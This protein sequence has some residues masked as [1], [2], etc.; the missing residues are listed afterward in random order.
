MAAP[1][2][3]SDDY[4]RALQA[5]MPRGPAWPRDPGAL[6]TKILTALAKVYEAQTQRSNNLLI[7]AF[8]GS[9]VELLPEWEASLG[10]PSTA[11]GP[12]P[13]VLARQTLVIAR[14]IGA[15]G[16]SVSDL[17]LYATL[18]G[19]EI[20]IAGCSPFRCGQSR[21]ADSLG[22]VEQM[23]GLRVTAP[24]DAQTPF[25]SYGPAVLQDELIRVSPPHAVLS[26]K[27]T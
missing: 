2:Y 6:Q 17:Q 22:G 12:N 3:S 26:F 9:A 1:Q 13:S 24:N 20:T 21:C 4:L 5:L 19:Y 15:L 27:F 23:F 7:D 18:L 10:L 8:P 25:G 11:A 14:F 16:V